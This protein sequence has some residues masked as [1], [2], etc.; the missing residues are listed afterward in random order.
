MMMQALESSN[1]TRLRTAAGIAAVL[2]SLMAIKMIAGMTR[3]PANNDFHNGEISGPVLALELARNAEDLRDVLQTEHPGEALKQPRDIESLTAYRAV[4]ALET[5]TIQ[6]CGFIPLYS[7]FLAAMIGVFT[8]HAAKS[9]TRLAAWLLIAAVAALDYAENIGIFRAIAASSLS[10]EAAHAIR[11]P[12]L[13]KWALLG[14]TLLVLGGAMI[15]SPVAA[16][17]ESARKLLG[18]LFALTGLMLLMATLC[19]MWFSWATQLFALL[20]IL[21][22]CGLLAPFFRVIIH[23]S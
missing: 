11:Y 23:R 16:M 18:M 4:S 9:R 2:A 6:D 1:I 13:A 14:V 3:Y 5:N 8:S 7:L 19:P 12:S 20:V 10:D 21:S 22:A 15:L 17:W